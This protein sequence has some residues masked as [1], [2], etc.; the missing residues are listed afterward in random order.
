M[1]LTKITTNILKD[2]VITSAKIADAAVTK[3]DIGYA[4]SILQVV[5]TVYNGTATYSGLTTW[6]NG[7]MSA[8]IT[9]FSANS[10]I[11]IFTTIIWDIAGE[12]TCLFRFTRNGTAIQTQTDAY[13]ATFGEGNNTN[14]SWATQTTNMQIDSPASTAALTYQLQIYPYDNTRTVYFNNSGAGGGV[15]DA[16]R[17]SRIVLM[18]ISG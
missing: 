9:P 6:A 1:A 13:A 12:T 8:S 16:L 18:E 17:Q 4:G 14:A 5:E 2:N 3:P 7:P 15:D 10:K 11:L